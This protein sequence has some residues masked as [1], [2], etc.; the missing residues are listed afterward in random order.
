LLFVFKISKTYEAIKMPLQEVE[1]EY[2]DD[3]GENSEQEKSQ[4]KN[5]V[6]V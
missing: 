4:A 2:D 6:G 5:Q 1:K 3:G